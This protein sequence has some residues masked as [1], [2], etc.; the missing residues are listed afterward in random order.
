V[1]DGRFAASRASV[2]AERGFGDEAIRQLLDVDGV[3]AELAEAAVVGLP[4]ERERAAGLVA[5]LGPSP[6]VLAQLQRKGF[7]LDALESA[8]GG[9]FADTDD[10]A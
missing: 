3:P 5:R 6:K 1:D 10:A 9:V 7:G 2:L 8:L 4:P